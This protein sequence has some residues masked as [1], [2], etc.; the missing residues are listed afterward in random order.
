[1][2]QTPKTNQPEQSSIFS[3]TDFQSREYDKNLSRARNALFIVAALQ[4]IGGLIIAFASNDENWLFD[5]GVY[6]VIALIFT[7]LGLWASTNPLE[8]LSVALVLFT[9]LIIFQLGTGS[10]RSLGGIIAKV[11]I[12]IYLAVGWND[13]RE[14][15]QSKKAAGR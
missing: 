14:A 3:D 11:I 12:L 1:M 15:R 13:A 10:I 7:A 6:T 2:D 8:A 9:A 5:L 4:F